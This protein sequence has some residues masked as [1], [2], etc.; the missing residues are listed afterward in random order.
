MVLYPLLFILVIME[1][2]NR[3]NYYFNVWFVS[4]ID[5]LGTVFV[6]VNHQVEIIDSSNEI[7]SPSTI[8]ICIELGFQNVETR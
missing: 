5:E 2:L 3:F 1:L 6:R 4:R 7:L 8:L